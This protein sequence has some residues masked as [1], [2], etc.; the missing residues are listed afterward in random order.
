MKKEKEQKKTCARLQKQLKTVLD[1][2]D[3]WKK[4]IKK[5]ENKASGRKTDIAQKIECLQQEA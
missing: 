3:L 5:L 4:H 1:R 2:I